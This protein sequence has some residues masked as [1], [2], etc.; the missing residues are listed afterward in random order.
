MPDTERTDSARLEAF[1]DGVFAVVITLLALDL[2]PELT[3]SARDSHALLWQLA[4]RWPTWLAF[5]TS[6][7]TVLIMWIDH[8]GLLKFVRRVDTPVLFANGLLMLLTTLVPFTTAL[9]SAHLTE[10]SGSMAGALYSGLFVLINGAFN[11]LWHLLRRQALPGA[12]EQRLTW[13]YRL[14]FPVYLV[15]TLVA[16]WRLPLSLVLCAGMWALWSAN[17]RPVHDGA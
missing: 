9:L 2:K 12:L 14:G 5:V 3:D 10:P 15:A 11:L 6:F 8:H 16:L 7:S 4:A 17:M 13:H 1:S